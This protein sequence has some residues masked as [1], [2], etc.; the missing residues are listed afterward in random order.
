MQLVILWLGALRGSLCW[1]PPGYS[2]LRVFSATGSGTLGSGTLGLMQQGSCD[3]SIGLVPASFIAFSEQL[4]RWP[5]NFCALRVPYT[6]SLFCGGRRGRLATG[7]D[8]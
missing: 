3:T 7:Y 2:D 1:G 6:A 5:L 8:A 4:D